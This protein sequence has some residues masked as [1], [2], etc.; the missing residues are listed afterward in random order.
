MSQNNAILLLIPSKHNLSHLL[1][2]SLK[3]TRPGGSWGGEVPREQEAIHGDHGGIS[4]GPWIWRGHPRARHL[5][6]KHQQQ[7]P[8]ERPR[9]SKPQRGLDLYSPDQIT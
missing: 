9:L 7:R 5:G 8:R 2:S 6:D 3:V 4:P 1:Y